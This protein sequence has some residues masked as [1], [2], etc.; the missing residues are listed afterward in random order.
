MNLSMFSRS[1]FRSVEKATT[2]S[3]RVQERK[4]GGEPAAAKPRSV[5]LISTS[6]NRGQSTSFGPDVSNI[7]VNPQLD[8][9]SVKGAAEN[10]ER[11]S[12]KGTAGNCERDSVQDRVQ[13]QKR[14][15]KCWNET[16]SLNG[17]AGNCNGQLPR[18]PV[19]KE[20]RET[21]CGTMS[22]A[23]CLKVQGV[24]GN[25]DERL[26]SNYRRPGW[27]TITCKSKITGT[28][29]KSS[30]IFVKNWTERWMMRCLTW[31]PTYWSGDYLCRQR[32]N[33]QFILAKIWSRARTPTSNGSRSCSISLCGWLRKIHSKFWIYLLWVDENDPVPWSCLGK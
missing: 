3:K 32:W 33:Q 7:S 29:R 24:A 2:M 6:L 4:M 13:T 14:V 9:G 18:A 27:T 25:C 1:H 15:L 30:R 8:S 22:K 11:D 28:L 23:T 5:C 16:S 21:A 17:V 19:Q 26:K 20:P 31:G 12:V 10:F